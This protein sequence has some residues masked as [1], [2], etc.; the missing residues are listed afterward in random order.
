M[1]SQVFSF[2]ICFQPITGAVSDP[3]MLL[4]LA[5]LVNPITANAIGI[6]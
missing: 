4:V 3:L 2:S 5:A 1:G 6:A